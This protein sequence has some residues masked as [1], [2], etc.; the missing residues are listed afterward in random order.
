MKAVFKKERIP[1]TVM[2]FWVFMI[3]TFTSNSLLVFPVLKFQEGK[4]DW[5]VLVNQIFFGATIAF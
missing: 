4:W 1:Q 3:L 2:F 5:L